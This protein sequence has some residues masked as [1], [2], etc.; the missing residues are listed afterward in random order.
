MCPYSLDHISLR[1]YALIFHNT[2]EPFVVR[3]SSISCNLLDTHPSAIPG[4]NIR[5]S[6]RLDL[7]LKKDVLLPIPILSK[8]NCVSDPREAES[9]TYRWR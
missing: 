4:E 2:H 8:N 5:T 6:R 9:L 7:L 3:K 1:S